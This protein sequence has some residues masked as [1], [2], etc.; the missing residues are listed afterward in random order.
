MDFN[1]RIWWFLS[2]YRRV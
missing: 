1:R 2:I